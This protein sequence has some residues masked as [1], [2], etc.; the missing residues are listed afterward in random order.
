MS[1]AANIVLPAPPM[2]KQTVAPLKPTVA[3]SACNLGCSWLSRSRR[4]KKAAGSTGHSCGVRTR[5]AAAVPDALVSEV[6]PLQPLI[7]LMF[8]RLCKVPCEE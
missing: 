2:P 1:E 7:A 3:V 6:S 5:V 4:G 8:D